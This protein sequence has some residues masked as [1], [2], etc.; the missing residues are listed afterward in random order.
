MRGI[1][2]AIC[3]RENSREGIHAATRTL[4]TE[5][6]ERNGLDR[7]DIVAVFFTMTPD[8]DADFPAH[9]ARTMG[10][11]DIPMLGAQ[12]SRVPKGTERV[13]RALVLAR[14]AGPV[15]HV[16]LGRAAAMRPDLAEPGDEQAWN[17]PGGPASDAPLGRALVVGLGLIGAS[18]A[19][20]ARRTGLFSAVVGHD[21][22]RDR[23]A[24]AA[25]MGLVDG[26]AAELRAE[27]A[28]ADLVVLA[29]PV[30]EI[31]AL[32]DRFAD[33]FKEGAVVTDVGSA[34]REIVA[35]MA[36]LP[37]GVRA[38]GGHPM[39]GDTASGPWAARPDLF[40][41]APWALVETPRSDGAALEAVR[42]FVRCVGA[43]PVLMDAETHDRAVAL[44]SHLP[45]V[46]AAAL[47]DVAARRRAASEDGQWLAGPGFVGT[48]RLAAGDP[49]MTGQMLGA[50]ADNLIEAID[51]LIDALAAYRVALAD[52]GR[53]L[54][55]RLR[56]AAAAR[57]SL[58]GRAA[59]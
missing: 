18:V 19:A 12:E 9:A 58:V 35:A 11:T 8:L 50:N 5:I 55:G 30:S 41:G 44:T 6:V 49:E 43:R 33:R 45:A 2:G 47:T 46:M 10:W 7:Q 29:V 31:S 27:L 51:E 14:G 17:G 53:A 34:K 16:Y 25:Q 52:G 21:R 39:A 15:R 4:L 48:T 3:A 23:A 1:R 38:V 57:A 28:R 26:A 24:L 20:A 42:R 36:R 59:D 32:L 22:D 56:D 54:V 13:I 40:R 37:D